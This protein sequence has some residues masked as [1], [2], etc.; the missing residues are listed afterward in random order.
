MSNTQ[1]RII[2]VSSAMQ[3]LLLIKNK[4]YGDAAINPTKTFSKLDGADSIRVRLD[5]KLNR[6]RNS[7]ETRYNDICDLIG[8]LTLLLI[9]EG[10]TKEDIEALID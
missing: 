7:E 6:V 9:A 1:D 10:V 3:S 2:E 5:D 4:R 8:Y